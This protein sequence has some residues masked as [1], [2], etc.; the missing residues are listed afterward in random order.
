MKDGMLDQQNLQL[1]FQMKIKNYQNALFSIQTE[2]PKKNKNQQYLD[3]IAKKLYY[4][5]INV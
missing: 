3:S 5:H 2:S 1:D 4:K